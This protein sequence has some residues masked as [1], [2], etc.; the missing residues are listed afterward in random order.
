MY[1]GGWG[2]AYLTLG[3][4]KSFSHTGNFTTISVSGTYTLPAGSTITVGS[5]FNG[6]YSWGSIAAGGKWFAGDANI[7]LN[8]SPA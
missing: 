1:S 8:I 3:D 6:D 4:V 5:N 2:R 7:T